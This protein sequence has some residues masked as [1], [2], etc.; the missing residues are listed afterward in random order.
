MMADI[1]FRKNSYDDAIYH[2]QQLLEGRAD[3]YEALAR[4]IGLLRRAGKLSEAPK[5]LG[6]SEK[7][8]ENTSQ[9][10]DVKKTD[11]GYNYCKGLYEW[12]V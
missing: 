12:Y 9:N 5:F 7:E 10:T 8:N 3:N 2:Y 4:L 11:S 6:L 1:M